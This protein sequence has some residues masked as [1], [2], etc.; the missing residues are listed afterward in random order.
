MANRKRVGWISGILGA[1][2]AAWAIVNTTISV[3]NLPAD[4]SD[5]WKAVVSA[6]ALIPYGL[7]CVCIAVLA[8]AI[9]WPDRQE[10]PSAEATSTLSG[11]AAVNLTLHPA[12]IEEKARQV[13]IDDAE[14]RRQMARNSPLARLIDGNWGDAAEKVLAD[15]KAK[16]EADREI[17]KRA[18]IREAETKAEDRGRKRALIAAGRDLV[19]RFR[20]SDESGFERFVGRDR[21]YLDIQPHLGDEYQAERIRSSKKITYSSENDEYRS[22]MFLREIARLEKEWGV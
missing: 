10:A 20:T 11:R 17:A 22:A 4:A 19:Q 8:W 13:A 7:T 18:A 1:I 15:Q 14:M 9:F 3:A 6:P 5:A 2:N 21:D 12:Y 16:E